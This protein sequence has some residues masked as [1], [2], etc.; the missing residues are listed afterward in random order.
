MH[1]VPLV[2][3]VIPCYNAEQYLAE[4]ITSVLS[5]TWQ[6]FEIIAVDDGSTDNTAN[7]LRSYG[8]KIRAEFSPNRGASAARNLGTT[9]ARGKFIQY[10]DADDLL[11]PD[12]LEKRIQALVS[13]DADVAYSDWQRLTENQ[14]GKFL[15]GDVI[16]RRIEDVHSDPQIALFTDFWAPPAALLYHRRIVEAIGSWNES[17]PIIQ[18]ARFLLDAALMGGKFVYVPGVQADYR[19]HKANSLSRRNPIKFVVDCFNNACQVEEFWK[20]N[21]GITSERQATLEQVYGGV[22]RFFFE[23]DRPT[24]YEA[25]AKIHALNPNYLPAGPRSLRQLSK[26]FGYEQ[27]E[28]IALNYR[29]LK[30]FTHSFTKK[31]PITSA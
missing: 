23:H 6:D 3:V 20:V 25:L 17:L 29:R 7:L 19:V 11:R 21:G 8:S 27:A 2:S 26:L 4:T 13:S 1:A 30:N 18:D 24:F 9:L 10:L 22:A 12:A 14:A 16:S 28:A 15:L 31:I 5:Q